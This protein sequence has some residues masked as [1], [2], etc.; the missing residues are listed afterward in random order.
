MKEPN[1]RE[2]SCYTLYMALFFYIHLVRSREKKRK[3]M[4]EVKKN[5]SS[6]SYV[7]SGVASVSI[8]Q[9]QL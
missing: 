3:K 6:A 7:D 4:E 1:P 9:I 2:Y 8:R 5:L